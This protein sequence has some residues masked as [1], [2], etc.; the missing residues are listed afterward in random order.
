MVSSMVVVT[1]PAAMVL[2]AKVQVAWV[3]RLAQVSWTGWLKPFS[4]E[5]LTRTLAEPPVSTEAEP[6][7]MM[8]LTG[9]GRCGGDDFEEDGGEA[10]R[11][12]CVAGVAGA[13]AVGSGG[14][15]GGG[16]SGEARGVEG[17]DAEDGVAVDEGDYTCGD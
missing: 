17:G 11:G 13:D 14:E 15:G 9:V 2:A 10:G 12:G 5:T 8:K 7:P 4:G 3:G 16:E 6:A 1:P